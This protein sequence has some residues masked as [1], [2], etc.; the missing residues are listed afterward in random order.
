[1]SKILMH[2]D[3]PVAK[4]NMMDPYIMGY[5]EIY[6]DKLIPI[7]TKVD[8]RLKS[9]EHYLIS[10][11]V[12]SRSIPDKRQ[13]I[14]RITQVLNMTPD[15]MFL[16]SLA[17]S[18]TD[19][20]WIKDEDSP[21]KWF[22]V[23]YFDN[24]FMSVVGNILKGQSPSFS[25]SPDFTTEGTMSKFWVAS[26]G[27]QY[28]YKIDNV[29]GSI[30]AANE[31]VVSKIMNNL[32]ILTTPYYF[33]KDDLG[34]NMCYCPNYIEDADID[35][36]N[37]LAIRHDHIGDFRPFSLVSYIENTLNMKDKLDEIRLIDVLFFNTD[38]HERNIGFS[39]KDN[40][41]STIKLI[42]AFDNGRCLGVDPVNS[43]EN[44]KLFGKPRDEVV[45]DIDN[46]PEIDEDMAFLILKE[47]YEQF[48]ISEEAYK[49]AYNILSEGLDL[50]KQRDLER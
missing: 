12:R 25:P 18:L 30:E 8:K 22:D 13:G 14:E 16:K 48:G 43:R 46:I 3:T 32:G 21:L 47:T 33:A 41:I 5:L 27:R 36:I 20:Y 7:G 40:D 42:P 29:S 44:L 15:E 37:A 10:E 1:M 34:N 49:K 28:L 26:G 23:N 31:V 50:L 11:W 4:L 2:K 35:Y 6:N 39:I 17:V 19:C 45:L 9:Q 38:R 24:G